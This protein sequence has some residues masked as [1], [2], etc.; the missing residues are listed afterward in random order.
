M[1]SL[2]QDT[3]LD[4]VTGGNRGGIDIDIYKSFNTGGTSVGNVYVSSYKAG[5]NTVL[6]GSSGGLNVNLLFG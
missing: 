6:I 5:G 4:T 1:I 2:L 3:D